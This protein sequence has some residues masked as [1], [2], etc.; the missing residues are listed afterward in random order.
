MIVKQMQDSGKWWKTGLTIGLGV[1]VAAG[2]IACILI[3]PCG[4]IAAGFI[5]AIAEI[6]T[7]IIA[8]ELVGLTTAL[9]GEA[10]IAG[11]ATVAEVEIG[12]SI[13][14]ELVADE[15]TEAV[16]QDVRNFR[17]EEPSSPPGAKLNA[18]GELR[19]V[20]KPD[21]AADAL[22]KRIGGVSRV[23]FANDPSGRE[24]DVISDRF[25]AQSKPANFKL[26]SAFRNQAR[27]T[28]EAAAKTGRSPYFHFEGPPEP[29][30]IAKIQEYADRYGIEPVID[31]QP[32]G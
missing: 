14:S 3:E 30:V 32:L 1:I 7:P 29:S 6:A 15:G 2:A 17:L 10:I 26:G 11:G 16:A 22:A 24:F 18:L 13:E 19:P 20:P 5:A 12:A 27:A 8:P 21:P 23:K 25:V 28:F 4:A 9:G 31:T